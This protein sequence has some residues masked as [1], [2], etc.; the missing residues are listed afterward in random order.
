MEEQRHSKVN[1]TSAM[2]NTQ[3]GTPI[4]CHV[5]PSPSTQAW[6]PV[7]GNP[8]PLQRGKEQHKEEEEDCQ[9]KAGTDTQ[10]LKVATHDTIQTETGLRIVGVNGRKANHRSNKLYTKKHIR[11]NKSIVL[12][13][14]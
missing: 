9:G 3:H 11:K 14:V 12:T 1:P 2:V 10:Q 6:E 5:C 13:H 4:L 8:R 7:S